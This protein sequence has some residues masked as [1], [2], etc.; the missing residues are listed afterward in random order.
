WYETG[1]SHEE[2]IRRMRYLPIKN[3][4]RSQ[5]GYQNN[6]YMIAGEIVA[7]VTGKSWSQ[8]VY[9]R[10]FGPLGMS[11]SRTSSKDL[12]QDL[13]IAYPH[14]QG[15][16]QQI[17]VQEPFAAG[18]IYSSVDDMSRWI[19]MLLNEGRWQGKTILSPASVEELFS[20]QTVIKLS[21][22]MKSHGSHFYAYGLGWFLFDYAG[23]K[24]VEHDGGMPGYISKVTLVP[25]EELGLVILTND[26]NILTGALRYK[27]LDTFFGQKETDWAA[28][29]LV[30]K[31]QR[32][33]AR[34][35]REAE[36]VAQRV[37]GTKPSLALAE[38]AGTY[39][40]EMY[41]D[42]RVDFD[43]KKLQ[44]TLL[45]AAEK[46]TSQME[47]WHY[48]TFRIKFRDAFLP[49]GFV[50]FHLDSKGQIADFTI[51][52]PNPDFHFF[53]LDFKRVAD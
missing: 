11:D 35:T 17:Y 7:R 49:A 21:P 30:F 19:R 51:D 52:L 50:T 25:E 4:F 33:E 3:E 32:E 5:F 44:V 10:I 2:I 37:A 14:L 27:I 13:D 24:I 38:Y 9:D 20:P 39:R 34:K 23:R 40:D 43:G 47:H 31:K 46:F 36:R 53:N 18:S 22:F 45:P 15:K 12:S 1:Y 6:M 41:G 16:L 29:Y 42:A 48:D 8:F 28:Q 26:M